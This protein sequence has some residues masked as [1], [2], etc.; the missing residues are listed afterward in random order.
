MGSL[1]N[2]KRGAEHTVTHVLGHPAK[3]KWSCAI[4]PRVFCKRKMPRACA[5][6]VACVALLVQL[7][8]GDFYDGAC[9]F[10][11]AFVHPSRT[12][13]GA[14]LPVWR[15]R[16]RV[17]HPPLRGSLSTTPHFPWP[18]PC[19]LPTHAPLC[20]AV[21]GVGQEASDAEIKKAYRKL[22]LQY[23]PGVWR[24]VC[25]GCPWGGNLQLPVV[26]WR[27][28]HSMGAVSPV[29]VGFS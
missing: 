24:V 1:Q 3:R 9:I 29:S 8:A 15:S 7:A 22:S 17:V 21:L 2:D 16:R 4:G 19:P 25:R 20:A 11:D 23:H 10:S 6:L 14:A 13:V 26:T 27:G 18:F 28:P 5:L 12:R